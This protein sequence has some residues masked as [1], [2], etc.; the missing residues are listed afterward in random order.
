MTSPTKNVILMTPGG[1]RSVN[2]CE[3]GVVTLDRVIKG[4]D[5]LSLRQFQ[6]IGL[7]NDWRSKRKQWKAMKE[8]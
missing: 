5:S 2:T 1:D 8:P 7:D 6:P 4:R 3:G